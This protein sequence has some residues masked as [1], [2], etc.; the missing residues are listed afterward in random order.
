MYAP[1]RAQLNSVG[2]YKSVSI[3]LLSFNANGLASNIEELVKCT[4]ECKVDIIMVQ[5]THLKQNR[6]NRQA[7][8]KG[9]TALYYD[10]LLYCCPIDIPRLTN[11][12]ATAC[13][14]SSRLSPDILDICLMK[15]VALKLSCIEIL[16]CLNSD[17]QPV[18]MRTMVE[19]SSRVVPA[20][21][22]RKEL[23]RDVSK[24]IKP[25]NSTWRRGDKYPICENARALQRK[26]KPR[27]EN[28]KN[29]NWC[30][31]MV[32]ISSSHQAYW[33]LAKALKTERAVPS[34]L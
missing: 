29:I 12:E 10:R 8:P 18:L 30:A 14:F 28:V 11:I 3:T 32:E 23:P 20:N 13:R 5:E 15:G 16:Q 34:P 22:D 21:S 25:K 6:T 2:R 27:I 19:N 4:Q 31:P 33:G 9:E 24:L 17:H 26:V 1:G 7:A